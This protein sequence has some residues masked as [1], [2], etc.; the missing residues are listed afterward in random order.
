MFMITPLIFGDERITVVAWLV[1]PSVLLKPWIVLRRTKCHDHG[2]V[3]PVG[4]LGNVCTSI[5]A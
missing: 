4:H 3:D 5:Q 1:T 2:P